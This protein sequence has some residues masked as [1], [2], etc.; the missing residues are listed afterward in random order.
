MRSGCA[1]LCQNPIVLDIG[2]SFRARSRC[3]KLLQTNESQRKL[4]TVG[5]ISRACEGGSPRMI[6]I[7][8]R[9]AGGQNRRHLD[10]RVCVPLLQCSEVQ[11]EFQIL[12]LQLF[13]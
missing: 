6:T 10:R 5:V 7:G 2:L 11:F 9:C 13:Q 4:S 3:R 1:A 8:Q 12:R